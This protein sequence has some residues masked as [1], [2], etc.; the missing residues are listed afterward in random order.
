VKWATATGGGGGATALAV[1]TTNG[2]TTVSVTG[3][4]VLVLNS[5]ANG[6]FTLNLTGVT[7]GQIII[8][9]N[10]S[11][12]TANYGTGLTI[13]NGTSQLLYVNDAGAVHLCGPNL[14]FTP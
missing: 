9:E 14:G 10:N 4:S 13:G 1:N 12:R 6:T 2:T 7:P 8:V 5:G 11:G 3:V